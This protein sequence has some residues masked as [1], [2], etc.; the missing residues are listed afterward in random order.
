MKLKKLQKTS[1]NN[2]TWLKKVEKQTQS[3]NIKLDHTQ[4]KE[5]FERVIKN[6]LKKKD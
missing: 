1:N 6:S 4:G 5:R 2:K 3:E